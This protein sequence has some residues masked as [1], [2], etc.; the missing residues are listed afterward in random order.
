MTKTTKTI[1]SKKRIVYLS[2]VALSGLFLTTYPYPVIAEGVDENP[3]TSITQP[4]GNL[5][6]NGDFTATENQTD[7]WTGSKASGWSAWIDKNYI[8]SSPSRQILADDNSVII[9]S[10]EPLRAVVH[11]TVQIDPSKKY[12]LRFKIMTEDKTGTAFVRILEGEGANKNLSHSPKVTGTND[13]Q[14]IEQE[15]RPI[16]SADKVKIEL[17]YETGIGIVA[18]KDVE[19]VEKLETTVSRTTSED[20]LEKAIHLP[21]N[22]KHILQ[23]SPYR[24][25]VED[26]SI[27]SLTGNILKP[28][29]QGNTTVHVYKE[30]ELIQSIP[31][32]VSPSTEDKYTQLLHDW[33]NM[34]VGNPFFDP[35]NPHMAAFNT[36]LEENVTKHL[37]TISSDQDQTSLW[38][39]LSDYQKSATITATYR[40]LEEMAKQ[41]TNPHSKY[42]QDE[43]VIRTVRASLDWLDKYVYNSSKEIVG[44]WWDYEIGTPRA[45]NNTLSLMQDYFSDEEIHRY[46]D[47]IEKFVPH[48]DQFRQTTNNPFKALGGNLVDMGRVKI[49]AGL[50]RKDETEISETIR[51]IEQVFSLVDKGEGFYPDGS[52]IDHTNVAYTGAYGNVLIDGLSQLLP[53]IQKTDTPLADEKLQVMYHWID[54]SFLPLI[55]HGELMDLSRGRS[56]SRTNSNDHVAAIEALRGIHRIAVMSDDATKMRLKS[57][58]KTIVQSDTF[59]DSFHNLKTYRDIRLME[60]LLNDSSIPTSTRSSYLSAFNKMDKLAYYNADKDFGFGLSMFSSRTK[61]Y[62][63]MNK[64]NRKGWYTGDGMFYL[65]N[66]DQS[67]YSNN[68]WP[69]VNPYA[70]PGTTETSGIREDDSG[71]VILPSGFVGIN[72]LDEQNAAAAMEFSNWNT[73]LSAHKSWFV[74]KDKVAFLGS[75]IKNTSGDVA[76]TTI[77]QRKNEPTNPY[78]IYVNNQPEM[79]SDQDREYK[80]TRSIFLESRDSNRNIGYFFFKKATISMMKRLQDGTWK[81]INQS[82]TDTPVQNEFITIHQ[83]HTVDNDSYAYMMIPNVTREEFERL[84]ASLENGL[85]ENNETTQIVYDTTQGIWGIVKY[86]DSVTTISDQFQVFKRGMYMIRKEVSG[87][88]VSYYNPETQ[89][90]APT[91]EVFKELIPTASSSVTSTSSPLSTNTSTISSIA[92]NSLPTQ[93]LTSD[94]SSSDSR[95]IESPTSS[96]T[97][98]TTSLSSDQTQQNSGTIQKKILPKTGE[99]TS[100]ALIVLGLVTGIFSLKW[101]KH[102]S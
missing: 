90:S 15:Y 87:Y 57:A 75:A 78:T 69:T 28:I 67:H 55:I 82:Q 43:T 4:S 46:T 95:Q 14:T 91:E 89:E 49:I 52:Y 8:N 26:P 59:Y 1:L 32:T 7:P 74:F 71:Q 98:T 29:K 24:Y 68:Y 48:S 76:S 97:K 37:T 88:T 27:A 99:L 5:L 79:I 41:V 77:D 65:Y 81:A 9:A 16:P 66:G 96:T 73:T 6:T 102:K 47:V 86:D 35:N 64:E 10:D 11:Q 22:K 51:S 83:A 80:D 45:I 21:L 85:W 50:L 70:L 92:T 61:N 17:F 94:T 2:A 23:S 63:G 20:T 93:P 60:E 56:I 13:W 19:L 101:L 44:N 33:N 84:S 30:Q 31:I 34:I 53:I 40:R 42:Y 62:E 54:H 100:L 18:F 12:I 38:P 25:E 3:T 39:D 58:I 36:E 72:K